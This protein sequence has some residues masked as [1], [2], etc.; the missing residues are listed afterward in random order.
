M[1]K[2]YNKTRIYRGALFVS[3]IC[4][5]SCKEQ[6]TEIKSITDY[7]LLERK[8][9]ITYTTEWAAVKKNDA[10]Y[11]RRLSNDPDEIKSI[12]GLISLYINEA[13]ITGN[14]DYYNA[15]AMTGIDQVLGMK[16]DQ[17]EALTFKATILLSQHQFSSALLVAEEI[18]NKYPYNAYLY[19]IITDAE[20]ELGNYEAAV[21]SAEKMISLRPDIRSYSRVAYLRE[22]HGDLT[23]AIEAM[24]LA[25]DAGG[26]GDE[27]TEWS[28]T[29]LGKLYEETGDT[30]NAIITYRIALQ[31]RN[32]FPP[33]LNGLARLALK[34]KN[35]V[36]AL[37]LF[38]QSDS[39]VSDHSSME[40]IAAVYEAT[41]QTQSAEYIR[42]SIFDRMKVY[43]GNGA[44]PKPSG[45]NE[46]LEMAHACAGIGDYSNALKYALVE[47]NRRPGN[48]E[49]NETVAMVYAKLGEFEKAVPYI[50][51]AMRT[52]SKKGE[53]ISLAEQIYSQTGK[54]KSQTTSKPV[55]NIQ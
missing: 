5:F 6:Q 41:D 44:V 8:S 4:F 54:I 31:N 34:E 53:L 24:K 42:Q 43:A 32:M 1:P 12:L 21:E 29:Q 36:R 46:D 19:G 51:N 7:K 40:G 52:N 22:I 55:A 47:Y 30:S 39:I 45:Q 50:E 38:K 20:L 17:F 14:Y 10:V 49:V 33:A 28:R 15:A 3:M 9:S 23:G 27:N 18:K 2:L 11:K 13:R 37:S 35:F 16:P 48:I 26:P 25:V